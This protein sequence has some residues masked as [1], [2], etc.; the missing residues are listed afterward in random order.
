MVSIKTPTLIGSFL[1][2]A[3]I[4]ELKGQGDQYSC[5]QQIRVNWQLA[6]LKYCFLWSLSIWP[7]SLSKRTWK[8]SFKTTILWWRIVGRVNIGTVPSVIESL[9]SDASRIE[10]PWQ[11]IWNKQWHFCG[12]LDVNLDRD[13]V[14]DCYWVSCPLKWNN[15][16][17]HSAC[18]GSTECSMARG[19]DCVMLWENMFLNS[20]TEMDPVHIISALPDEA[21]SPDGVF[22]WGV[23]GCW[24]TGNLTTTDC[25]D[26]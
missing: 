12:I 8:G 4:L 19:G 24:E 11:G 26:I 14:L 18:D 13:W 25:N 7:M 6:C 15:A 5:Y 3:G 16:V 1:L 2:G 9:E 21:T 10:S 17:T 22:Q 23:G 20:P